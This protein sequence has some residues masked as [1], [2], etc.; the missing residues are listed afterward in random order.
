[1]KQTKHTMQEYRWSLAEKLGIIPPGP[2]SQDWEYEVAEAAQLHTYL[3]AYRHTP[4]IDQEKYY[5]FRMIL[6]ALNDGFDPEH[7]AIKE[8]CASIEGIIV[9][10]YPLH[11]E[12]LD[13][14]AM[15]DEDDTE[16]VFSIT[17][18][19]RDVL[20]RNQGVYPIS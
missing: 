10:D 5:L 18:Y 12:T 17:P 9:K 13:V 19:I 2:Y 8:A 16:N 20:Y 3:T 11:K 4:L 14:W 1:M 6:Q 7:Q 15:H